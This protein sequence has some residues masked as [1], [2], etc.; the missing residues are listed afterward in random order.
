MPFGNTVL[1]VVKFFHI[2]ILMLFETYFYITEDENSC[3]I[4]NL[5]YSSL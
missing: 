1:F 3:T 5:S 2:N 4:D